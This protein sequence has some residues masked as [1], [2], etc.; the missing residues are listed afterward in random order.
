M[1][2]SLLQDWVTICGASSISSIVQGADC[3][4]DIG[5]CEDLAFFLDVRDVSNA[6]IVYETSPSKQ[7]QNFV[8]MVGLITPAIGQR[9]D[10]VFFSFASVPPARIRCVV[11]RGT[12]SFAFPRATSWC[13]M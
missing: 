6:Q 10:R 8:A 7:E 4:L 9:V 1:H 13:S 2:G 12:P 3:W 11:A 5:D